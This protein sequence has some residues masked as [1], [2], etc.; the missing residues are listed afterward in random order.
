MIWGSCKNEEVLR[1]FLEKSEKARENFSFY[2]NRPLLYI[3]TLEKV[4]WGK[5]GNTIVSYGH[6]DRI[7]S[8]RCW[9]GLCVSDDYQGKGFGRKTL[10]RLFCEA[11]GIGLKYLNLSVYK[12]NA[13]AINLYKSEGFLKVEEENNNFFMEKEL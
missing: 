9:V 1:S 6:L 4:V 10:K 2:L 7:N 11:S 8:E 13:P 5:L 3:T 12:S